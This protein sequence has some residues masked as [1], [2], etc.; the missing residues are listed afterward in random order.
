M[1]TKYETIGNRPKP[2]ENNGA[3]IYKGKMYVFGGYDG[4]SWLN[5]FYA[6]DLVTLQWSLVEQKGQR[7]S[8]RF[9][10]ASG[11]HEQCLIVFGGF[12]GN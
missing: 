1:W 6:L 11:V 3:Q 9:G 12:D 7:P 4:N 10:F 8:E 2:R 5:D